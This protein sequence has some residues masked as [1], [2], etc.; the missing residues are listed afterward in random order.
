MPCSHNDGADPKDSCMTRL[1]ASLR[2]WQKSLIPLVLCALV[3]TGLSAKLLVSLADTDRSYSDLVEKRSPAAVWAS[4]MGASVVDLSRLTWRAMA[5][6]SAD[7]VAERRDLE[8]LLTIYGERTGET[9]KLLGTNPLAAQLPQFQQRFEAVHKVALEAL[10]M[11]Q[12]GMGAE[13]VELM[14]AR[15]NQPFAALRADLLTYA[16]TILDQAEAYGQQVSAEAEATETQAIYLAAGSI[17]AVLLLGA[18]MAMKGVVAPVRALTATM[19]TLAGGKLDTDVPGTTRGDELGGMARSVETFRQGLLEVERLKADQEAQKLRAEEEKRASMNA[20]ADR[21]QQS[22]GGVVDTLSSA[23]TELTAAAES[24]ASIAEETSRQAT[25]V[26]SASEQATTNVQTVASAAEELSSSVSEISRQVAQSTQIAGQAM[27]EVDQTNKTVQ[28][29]TGSVSRIS[30][31]VRLISEIA[32]QTNLLALN[33]TIEAARAGDAGKGFAVVASE[34]KHLAT[35]T[36]RATEDI[37]GRIG[38]IQ[39]ATGQSV[40][41]IERINKVIQQMNEISLAIASAVE[42]Q[43]AATQEI[44]RNVAQ[45]ADGTQLVSSNILQVTQASAETGTAASQVQA[46]SA[47]VAQQADGLRTEVANFLRQVRAA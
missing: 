30:E 2:I 10:A 16:E 37:A 35:Q 13:G 14:Q 45:A 36:A 19:D 3:A 26:A 6:S 5:D 47:E 27:T 25:T 34:V 12:A 46:S 24:M 38:E 21:F 29:L 20:L 40:E 9:R 28:G 41:A 42:E 18:W 43:G 22:V 33:A 39:G 1:L 31:V 44:A 32:S 8:K 23:S 15:F 7:P 11:S 4:R 17:I